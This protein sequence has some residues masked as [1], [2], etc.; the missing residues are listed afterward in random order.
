MKITFWGSPEAAVIV[1]DRLIGDGQDVAA[2]VT[3]PDKPAGRKRIV[4]ACA[5][6]ARA[7]EKG[8]TVFQPE[9]LRDEVFA[10]ELQLIGADAAVVVAYGKLIPADLLALPRFGFLNVHFSLLP[11]HRGASPVAAAILAGDRETGV[12]IMRL[13]Q[14][15]DTGPVLAQ[16]TMTLTGDDR[17]GPLTTGLAEAGAGAIAELLR[18]LEAGDEIPAKAQDESLATLCR[19]IEKGDGRIDW[20]LPAADLDRRLRAF[21]PWPG[22]FSMLGSERVKVKQARPDPDDTGGAVE[23]GMMLKVSGEEITVSTGRG[24]LVLV[25]VQPEGKGEMSA[26]AFAHGRRLVPGAKFS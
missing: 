3:Q 1:L 2:V 17:T 7:K 4:T 21:D 9:K 23:P 12:T 20:N 15:L 19:P 5:V 22:V 24:S 18:K 8:L 10:R 25:R 16:R 14:G 6:A 11:R 26:G 13:D